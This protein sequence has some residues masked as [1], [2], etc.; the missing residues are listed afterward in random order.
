MSHAISVLIVTWNSAA[1]I[2]ACLA[3]LPADVEV[4]VVDNHSSDGT[5]AQIRQAFPAVRVLESATNLGFGAACNWAAQEATGSYYLLLNPDAALAPGAL[6]G[7][8]A[9]LERLPGGAAVGPRLLD[10]DGGLELS[11]GESPTPRTEWRRRA[12]QLGKRSASP[13]REL[14]S[15]DWISGACIL[16][17]AEAWK[18][19]GGFDEGFF[20]YFE[21][22]DLCR[23]L[24]DAG[25]AIGYE[26]AHPVIHLRG[27][28]SDQ[29]SAQV[30]VWYRMG[31]L[32]YYAKHNPWLQRLMLRAHLVVKFAIRA[33]RGD[34]AAGRV[35]K[36]ALGVPSSFRVP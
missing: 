9:S 20:L 16:I 26:P 34:P 17:R 22:V 31:Q 24:T 19:I 33:L 32:R 8:L 36:L 10:A 7:L 12:E 29:A 30:E 23:R 11:W 1:T 2:E 4:I 13:P 28:S 21:D 5:A 3:S 18:A 25:W 35:L 15:V 6:D 14:S 27:R